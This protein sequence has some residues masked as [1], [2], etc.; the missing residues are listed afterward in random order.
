MLKRSQLKRGQS[1]L[2]KTSSLKKT[3]KL[4]SKK[5]TAEQ[6]A[7]DKEQR[8]KD[9]TFY[10]EIWNERK[11]VSEASGKW[12]GDEPRTVYFDHLLEKSTYPHL[13]YEKE[14]IMLLTWEEHSNKYNKPHPEHIKR[15]NQA[16]Q[17]FGIE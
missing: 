6:L 2:K 7:A 1:T 11:H 10:L 15:I 4:K 9:W 12:L 16:K 17:R 3:G 8:E 14:N 13:R 5:P